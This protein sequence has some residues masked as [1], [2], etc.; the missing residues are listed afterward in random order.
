MDKQFQNP[1][2]IALADTWNRCKELVLKT[3][4]L[5][6]AQLLSGAIML[7]S[8]VVVLLVCCVLWVYGGFA[9]MV[10]IFHHLIA[11]QLFAMRDK[12][13][14]SIEKFPM[15]ISIG[16]F[17]VCWLIFAIISLPIYI[18]G[19]LASLFVE[20]VWG[21]LLVLALL[22][23]CAAVYFYRWQLLLWAANTFPALFPK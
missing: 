18:I 13:G 14:T 9:V 1:I 19:G 2:H 8:Y 12:C 11:T 20:S 7:I 15:L 21:K 5:R 6:P 4:W 10:Q 22:A 17:A 16:L 3:Q 23:V